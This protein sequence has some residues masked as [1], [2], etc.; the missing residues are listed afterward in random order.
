MRSIESRG[1]ERRMEGAKIEDEAQTHVYLSDDIFNREIAKKLVS[2]NP[3]NK[4]R[5][6]Y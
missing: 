2:G 6:N 5:P 1:G 3:N 4:K